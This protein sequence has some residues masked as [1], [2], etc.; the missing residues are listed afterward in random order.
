M[1][2]IWHSGINSYHAFSADGANWTAIDT[3]MFSTA[4]NISAAAP[5][6]SPGTA[7]AAAAAP[8]ASAADCSLL[9]S[10]SA[11][12][13]QCSPGY[14]GPTCGQLALRPAASLAAATLW[15]QP[16]VGNSSAWGFTVAFDPTDRLYHAVADVSC[17]CDKTSPVR[18]CTEFTGVLASGGYASS[19]VHLTSSR[20]DGGFK[21]VSVLAPATSFNPHLVRSPAGVFALYFRVNAVDPLPLCSGDPA[22]PTSSEGSLIKVCVGSNRENCIHAGGA[23]S[24]T[25]MYVAT[26]RSM[27]GPWRV[28][29][30]TVAGEGALHVSNPSVAFIRP[31]TPAASLGKVAI[32]FRYNSPHGENNGIGFADDPA[33]P[34]RAVANLSFAPDTPAAM[35]SAAW[36][37]GVFELKRRERPELH[38]HDSSDGHNAVL[39]NGASAM[40]NGVYRAFSLVQAVG[41]SGNEP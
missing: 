21:F 3:P 6:P 8:C 7:A 4:L 14:T 37:E 23:E 40:V 12:V 5:A 34:F 16:G 2:C 9:G 22:G 17:G 30:V 35:G 15:P 18:E 27:R 28:R 25:N 24:G 26:A 38:D 19:L 13:C 32:S 39:Y 41:A 36:G 10:C 29:P 20:P 11:G 31:G 33:G 1:H